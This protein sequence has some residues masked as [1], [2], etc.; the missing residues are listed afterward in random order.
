MPTQL[1]TILPARVAKSKIPGVYKAIA[2]LYNIWGALTES[3]ARRRCLEVAQIQDGERVLEV[4]VGTGL[5]FSQIIQLN[6]SGWNEGLDLTPEML[7]KAERR[8][9]STGA[10]NYRLRPGD[11]YHL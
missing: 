11:A 9:A 8:V 2:P 7:A 10:K 3:K 4:A 1:F 5:L 6:P